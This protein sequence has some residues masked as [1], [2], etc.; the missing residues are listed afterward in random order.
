MK[1]QILAA[2][3]AA[4]LLILPAAPASATSTESDT[5]GCKAT[6]RAGTTVFF[7]PRPMSPHAIAGEPVEDTKVRVIGVDTS[8]YAS[9]EI[10]SFHPE[11]GIFL[12]YPYTY[13][14]SGTYLPAGYVEPGAL[15]QT[16]QL[17]QCLARRF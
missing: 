11:P 17:E 6:L 2:A 14:G 12:L 9:L 13:D 1:R 5:K 16:K 3:A 4:A 8:A 10:E 7:T 15:K